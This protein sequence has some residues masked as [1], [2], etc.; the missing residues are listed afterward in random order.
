MNKTSGKFWKDSR[1]NQKTSDK[2]RKKSGKGEN[3]F[4]RFFKSVFNFKD[5]PWK[6]EILQYF[7]AALILI[8]SS[9]LDKDEDKDE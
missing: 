3:V 5:H 9:R 1:K 4:S 7:I 8:I 6:T 2:D